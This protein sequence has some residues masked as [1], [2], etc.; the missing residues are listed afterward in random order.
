MC[1]HVCSRPFG[2]N[3]RRQGNH[4]SAALG[5]T[6]NS[7]D[8]DRLTGVF[9]LVWRRP[10]Q[11]SGACALAIAKLAHI[12][13][14]NKVQPQQRGRMVS[15]PRMPVGPCQEVFVRCGMFSTGE[16]RKVGTCVRCSCWAQQHVVVF[17]WC[18]GCVYWQ[19][20]SVGCTRA[21]WALVHIHGAVQL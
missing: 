14:T 6:R 16:D 20:V 12:E 17:R 4:A 3:R 13:I 8:G 15:G 1:G 18:F 2:T 5:T 7:C 21:M 11:A 19:P 9:P 10:S